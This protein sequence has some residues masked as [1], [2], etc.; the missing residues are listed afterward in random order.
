M[1]ISLYT[2]Y[3]R[4]KDDTQ[5]KITDELIQFIVDLLNFQ[6][7][8]S[9]S[10]KKPSD[11]LPDKIIFQSQTNENNLNALGLPITNKGD[12]QSSYA[13]YSHELSL[14]TIVEKV[15]S[16]TRSEPNEWISDFERRNMD[17]NDLLWRRLFLLSNNDS[18]DIKTLWT[19]F[20]IRRENTSDKKQ[21]FLRDKVNFGPPL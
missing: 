16:I 20:A 5:E 17:R 15:Y 8:Y 4:L 7:E 3:Q 11:K 10:D 14:L 18:F 9:P 6:Q 1:F 19:S 13:N 12:V 2:L 21:K